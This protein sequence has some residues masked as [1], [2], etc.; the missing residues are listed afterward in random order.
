MLPV[1]ID[2]TSGRR[3]S[4][5][6]CRSI[7]G[8][9]ASVYISSSASCDPLKVK[10]EIKTF[11]YIHEFLTYLSSNIKYYIYL[12]WRRKLIFPIEH[13]IIIGV[14][15]NAPLTCI[16][17]NFFYGEQPGKTAAKQ[18]FFLRTEIKAKITIWIYLSDRKPKWL[19]FI[20]KLLFKKIIIVFEKISSKKLFLALFQNNEFIFKQPA[21]CSLPFLNEIF[22][23]FFNTLNFCHLENI[24]RK[25]SPK[26][27]QYLIALFQQ[28]EFLSRVVAV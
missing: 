11:P 17:F 28:T 4:S 15:V 2:R 10:T 16:Q 3:S 7:V 27:L 21:F 6:G 5:I 22:L 18:D 14:L 20:L 24:I 8:R 23:R 1:P 12:W 13:N 19:F 26:K 9:R 25:K